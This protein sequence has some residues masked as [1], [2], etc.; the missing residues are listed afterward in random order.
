MTDNTPV[1][2][3]SDLFFYYLFC[4]AII[5]SSCCHSHCALTSCVC[6]FA[7]QVVLESRCSDR[8]PLRWSWRR[9]ACGRRNYPQSFTWPPIPLCCTHLVSRLGL[10]SLRLN[11]AIERTLDL[12]IIL[13]L[14]LFPLS[15][16]P[17]VCFLTFPF[18][19][20]WTKI[21]PESI[22]TPPPHQTHKHSHTLS[23]LF[24]SPLF[25][26]EALCLLQSEALT[27]TFH[28]G[29]SCTSQQH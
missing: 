19:T 13:Y 8:Q 10:I 18:H 16:L 15:F 21:R 11:W 17:F 26:K 9:C 27:M 3:I 25:M 2:W 7:Q 22:Y 29:L 28:G 20:I 6:S 14:A 4:F 23:S 12:V 24:L 5:W 1:S